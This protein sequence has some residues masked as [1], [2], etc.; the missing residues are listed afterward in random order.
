MIYAR[1]MIFRI[2]LFTI[3]ALAVVGL[4]LLLNGLGASPGLA[5]AVYAVI[6]V[7]TG[8]TI[9]YFVDRLPELPFR[10]PGHPAPPLRHYH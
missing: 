5:V 1:N 7:S 4:T 9:G 6:A 3:P 8:A 10:R 2:A